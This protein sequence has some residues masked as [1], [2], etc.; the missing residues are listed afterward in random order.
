MNTEGWKLKEVVIY[1][2]LFESV[3]IALLTKI[4]K[5]KKKITKQYKINRQFL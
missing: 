3:L 1:L 2:L 5:L 4:K